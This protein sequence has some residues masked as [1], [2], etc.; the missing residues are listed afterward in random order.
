MVLSRCEW[1]DDDYSLNVANLPI[2]QPDFDIEQ[3]QTSKNKSK[4][5]NSAQDDLFGE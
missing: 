3:S 5:I 2:A 4:K 1:A